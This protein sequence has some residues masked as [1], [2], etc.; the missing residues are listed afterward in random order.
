MT[1]RLS[2]G[3]RRWRG[4]SRLVEHNE[5]GIR[6]RDEESWVDWNREGRARLLVLA[7]GTRVLLGQCKRKQDQ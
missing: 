6:E 5:A 3:T 4:C 2:V 1:E 7:A